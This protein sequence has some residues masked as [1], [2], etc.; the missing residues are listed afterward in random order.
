MYVNKSQ[1]PKDYDAIMLYALKL[2]ARKRYTQKELENKFRDKKIGLKVDQQKAIA[3]LK[4][5]KYI[6]D[7][8]FAKDYIQTRL[9]INPKGP[10]LLKLELKLKG[11]DKQIIDTAIEQ[12]DID[13]LQIALNVLER[14]KKA[15]NRTEGRKRKEK[16]MRTLSSRGFKLDTIYKILE[17][18]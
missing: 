7:K 5:L 13:E 12:A 17:K 8:E 2:I 6:N 4:V 15:I 9:L 1:K 3:R 10:Y 11:V 18:W 14:K 16:I